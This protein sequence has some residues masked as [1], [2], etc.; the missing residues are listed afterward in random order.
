MKNIHC[1]VFGHDLKVTREVTLHVKEYTCKNCR[2]E[3]TTSSNGNLTALT[4]KY[5][6]INMV[7]QHIREKRALKKSHQLLN[8][9]LLVFKH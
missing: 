4:S 2:K 5:K 3:Y 9:D 6:E 7:L 8:N 1:K